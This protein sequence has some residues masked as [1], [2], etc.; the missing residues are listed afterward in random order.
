[1]SVMSTW[2]G[3]LPDA[4]QVHD[5]WREAKKKVSGGSLP[6]AEAAAE[7][8]RVGV[9]ADEAFV[10]LEPH[11]ARL[12][13]A[14]ASLS[15]LDEPDEVFGVL[16]LATAALIHGRLDGYDFD[17]E[18]RIVRELTVQGTRS[19]SFAYV[20]LA[21]G[22]TEAYSKFW[23]DG[24]LARLARGD[25]RAYGDWVAAFPTSDFSYAEL[26]LVA[27]AWV[28]IVE[29]RGRAGIGGAARWLH[30]TV[31]EG[32]IPSVPPPPVPTTTNASPFDVPW[33]IE[34]A[35]PVNVSDPPYSS[36]YVVPTWI[37]V[38]DVQGLWGGRHVDIAADG[39]VT[40]IVVAS[41]RTRTETKGELTADERA[42]LGR[43]IEANDP[44]TLRP[45]ERG[46]IPDEVLISLSYVAGG[47]T[48]SVS[49]WANDHDRGFDEVVYA[50]SSIGHRVA[51]S[52]T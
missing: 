17:R 44:R 18:A 40:V 3:Y 10:V 24:I 37:S 39:T 29:Q 1:M 26:G 43:V 48:T 35:E 13:E 41:D 5:V 7:A 32:R 6:F 12:K 45:S 51:P 21:I 52:G 2:V 9:L 42:Q 27:R 4:E 50:V 22:W 8:V 11:L 23:D 38:N 33:R 36:A 19:R 16:A 15:V 31:R 25:A 20:A 28:A 34:R 46:G 49:R 30:R 14:F 47:A